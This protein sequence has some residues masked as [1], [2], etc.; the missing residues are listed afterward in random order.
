MSWVYIIFDG[1]TL[2]K[3]HVILEVGGLV[4][5]RNWNDTKSNNN[6]LYYF[7]WLSLCNL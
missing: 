1:K 4:Q 2:K 5:E 3:E 7:I 6:F